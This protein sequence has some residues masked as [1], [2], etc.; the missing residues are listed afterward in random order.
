MTG[1]VYGFS[2]IAQLLADVSPTIKN[3]SDYANGSGA[4]MVRQRA[5]QLRR[6]LGDHAR[7]VTTVRGHGYR[8]DV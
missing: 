7:H 6:R 2:I 8:L 5:H 3:P 4:D 1:V